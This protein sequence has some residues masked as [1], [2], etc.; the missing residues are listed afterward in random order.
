M[1][2]DWE[3]G[4]RMTTGAAVAL[5]SDATGPDLRMNFGIS[6]GM[7]S[8]PATPF[9]TVNVPPITSRGNHGS[10]SAALYGLPRKRGKAQSAQIEISP[11]TRASA[12]ASVR[13]FA[14]S[15]SRALWE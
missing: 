1:T 12:T 5:V 10:G 8:L 3:R 13:V 15:F 4:G 11:R 9:A 2:A 6:P 7:E 14:P